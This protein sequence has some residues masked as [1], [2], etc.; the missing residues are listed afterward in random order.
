MDPLDPIFIIA[1]K[2]NLLQL[3]ANV[4]SATLLVI[5][6]CVLIVISF[7]IA[8]TQAAIFSLEDKEVDILKTKQQS[9]AKRILDLLDEPKEV[10]VSMLI[11]KTFCNICIIVLANY[12][13][14]LYI[15]PEFLS[16]SWAIVLK[17][18]AIAFVLLFLVEIFPRVWASQNNLR[19]A[20]EWPVLIMIVEGI[21]LI[22]RRISNWIVSIADSVGR[23]V[24]A[25]KTEENSFQQLDQAIDIQ[26]D[27]NVSPEEKD[28]IK[29]IVKFGKISVKKAMRSRLYVSGIEYKTSFPELIEKIKELQYS[30]LPIYKENLDN[31]AGILN[32]KDLVPHLYENN[33]PDF[34]WHTKIRVPYFVPESKL[35]EDLLVDFQKKRIHFAVV[36]D[37]FG[38]TSGIVTMEDIIE[39]VIG[40]IKDEFDEEESG[41]KKI[42][43]RNY[44]FE[45]RTMLHDVCKAIKLPIDTFDK[46]RGENE[47]IGGLVVELLGE[48]PKTDN[49][50]TAG[51]FEFTVLETEKNRVKQV[52]VRV[53][54]VD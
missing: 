14:N 10:F 51:D 48:L 15:P 1:G 49:V 38:G 18:L 54:N 36:V 35:I 2:L 24:G 30:R 29:G 4:Q 41:I 43:D 50:V 22:L 37:E 6:L 25:Y 9:S 44:I 12:L 28:I 11:A 3:P 40:D 42:D 34:D 46:V 39:E 31:I 8:G 16:N 5:L 45:G 19:F 47:S 20:F 26:T 7:S 27:E 23:G 17:F 21:H 32:T 52:R 53:T 33:S 13:I